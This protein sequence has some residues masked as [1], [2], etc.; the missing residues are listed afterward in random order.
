MYSYISNG[1][2]IEDAST[3]MHIPYLGIE[4]LHLTC[5]EA[6]RPAGGFVIGGE[7]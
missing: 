7:E 5:L 3:W 4:S 2:M 6:L 1:Q